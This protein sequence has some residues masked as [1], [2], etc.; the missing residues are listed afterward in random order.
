MW[1][2]TSWHS[3]SVSRVVV[4]DRVGT[5]NSDFLGTRNQPKN[6]FKASWTRPFFISLPN[7]CHIRR[8]FKVSHCL[9]WKYKLICTKIGTDP[10]LFSKEFIKPQNHN[11]Y[12]KQQETRPIFF[13]RFSPMAK[14]VSSILDLLEFGVLGN[15]VS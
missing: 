6:G 12:E 9:R 7:F 5:R 3:C 2:N 10:T 11:V 14:Q 13:L 4:A 15:S 1:N 8:F